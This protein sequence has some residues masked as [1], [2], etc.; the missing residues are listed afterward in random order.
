MYNKFNFDYLESI[1]I[2][3]QKNDYKFTPLEELSGD[4]SANK[5]K[6]SLRLDIEFQP[7][8]LENFLV[9]TKKY[10]IPMTIYVRVS[11]PYNIFWYNTYKFLKRAKNEGH[12]IGLHTTPFEW[13]KLNN[14]N[15]ND[16]LD[17]E[18]K[19]LKKFF[20]IKSVSTHRDLNYAY[21]SL[22]W[23]EEN[24]NHIKKKYDLKYHAY[25][26]KFFE[27]IEYVNEGFNPHICWRN[28]TPEECI[29]SGKTI[30]MLLHPHWWFR[31]N[32]FEHEY[33]L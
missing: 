25:E 15:P 32:P 21:N 16:I 27:N 24:W 7:H 6:F 5:K 20:D 8:S 13:S 17:V 4:D 33:S 19:L 26:K 22:P 28:K 10:N 29:K 30:Y 14:E 2:L 31:D 18:I 9:L 12:E 1:F 3:A 11:G 23:L